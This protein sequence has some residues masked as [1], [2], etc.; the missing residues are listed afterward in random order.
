MVDDISPISREERL[1]RI[2]NAQAI[3]AKQDI[4]AIVLEP[5]AAMVYFS[6]IQWWRSERLTAVVIPR[7]G[8]VA[9]VC[10]FFEEPSIRESL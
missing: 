8:D 5:G 2:A 4:D 6:G 9:V 1:V 3:M 10:P 7:K